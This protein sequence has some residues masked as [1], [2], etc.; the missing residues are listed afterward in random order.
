MSL[1]N[2]VGMYSKA[3]QALMQTYALDVHAVIHSIIVRNIVV[4]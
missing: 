4:C 3:P 2:I 1:H